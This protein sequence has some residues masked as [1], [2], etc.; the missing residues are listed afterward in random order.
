MW[1]SHVGRMKV[2]RLT[3]RMYETKTLKGGIV[4]DLGEPDTVGRSNSQKGEERIGAN[5]ADNHFG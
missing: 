2:E 5:E 4:I 1:F 3:K